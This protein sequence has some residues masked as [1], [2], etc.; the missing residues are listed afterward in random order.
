RSRSCNI[1][2]E[3]LPS[4]RIR[5]GCRQAPRGTAVEEPQKGELMR[6]WLAVLAAV[7][8]VL[9]LPSLASA[10]PPANDAYAAAEVISAPSGTVF[11]SGVDAKTGAGERPAMPQLH[12]IWYAG[13]APTYGTLSF[14]TAGTAWAWVFHGDGLATADMLVNGQH[15]GF[16]SVRPGET[17]RI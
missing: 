7:V 15:S 3:A 13:A 10:A 1:E 6:G 11:G 8:A 17:Y 5:E 2:N 9:A 12:S 4:A 16:I 14:G